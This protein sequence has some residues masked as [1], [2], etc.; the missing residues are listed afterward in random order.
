MFLQSCGHWQG[1]ALKHTHTHT[2]S[3]S[4]FSR[5]NSAFREFQQGEEVQEVVTSYRAGGVVSVL[6]LK[7]AEPSQVLTGT[8]V[9]VRVQTGRVG[10]EAGTQPCGVG[11]SG[12]RWSLPAVTELE[13][14]FSHFERGALSGNGSPRSG[15]QLTWTS[16]PPSG[17]GSAALRRSSRSL[18]RNSPESKR[19][20][21]GVA[22]QLVRSDRIGV[23]HQKIN[24]SV[25]FG[26]SE[27]L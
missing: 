9:E 15:S 26:P 23:I 13:E 16:S 25:W 24:E 4:V 7:A 21:S 2:L 18:V 17:S 10:P 6:Q 19:K 1:C 5:N 22:S 14:L 8:R 12:T 11:L 27:A 3:R 20:F